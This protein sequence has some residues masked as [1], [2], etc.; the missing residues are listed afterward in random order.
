MDTPHREDD[1][2]FRYQLIAPLLD[3]D[4]Q[5]GEQAQQLKAIASPEHRHPVRG[6]VR[7]SVASLKRYLRRYRKAGHGQ[8]KVQALQCKERADKGSARPV[9]LELAVQLRKEVPERSVARLIHLMELR[10]EPP[11]YPCPVLMG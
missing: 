3:P 8:S 10:G 4:L 7:C 6:R 1:A 5:R 11:D 2:L 9:V